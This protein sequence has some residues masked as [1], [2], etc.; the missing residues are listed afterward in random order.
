M[1]HA[2][3]HAFSSATKFGGVPEDY[4]TIHEWFDET[5]A[6]VTGPQHRALRHHTLGIRTAEKI[7]NYRIKNS[8]GK[9]VLVRAIGEQHVT[10]D[11][12]RVFTPADWLQHLKIPRELNK[13]QKIQT[14]LAVDIPDS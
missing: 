5:S 13:P 4:I 1:A 12:G 2:Y 14:N 9:F 6:F 7:F 10:E 8:A 11:L 3:E